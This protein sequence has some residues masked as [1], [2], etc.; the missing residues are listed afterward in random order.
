M[1]SS[2]DLLTFRLVQTWEADHL[3]AM[4]ST[5]FLV[6]RG[7]VAGDERTSCLVDWVAEDLVSEP[8]IEAVM[9]RFEGTKA[10]SFVRSGRPIASVQAGE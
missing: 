10:L 9:A 8:V 4:A 5:D 7:D 2:G 1:R 6:E 3:E